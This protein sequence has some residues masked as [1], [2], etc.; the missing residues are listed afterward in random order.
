[1]LYWNDGENSLYKSDVMEVLGLLP[2]D[3]VDCVWTDP[4]YFLSDGGTTN[5]SG[6]R[7]KVDKGEW[8]APRSHQEHFSW[9]LQWIQECYRV[10]R[11]GGCIWLSGTVHAHPLLGMALLDC[12]YEIINDIVWEKPAPPP[13]LGRRSFTHS[14][15]LLYW[16]VK[17]GKRARYTF[18]YDDVRAGNEGKQVKTVWKI[19]P[20]NNEEKKHGKHPTQKPLELIDR[21]LEATTN[22]GDLVLDPFCGSG[23]SGVSALRLGRIWIGND[24]DIEQEYL[25]IAV[26]RL[27]EV[28]NALAQ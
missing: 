16:A 21:C 6:K 14:T 11:P 3:M 27:E 13:N 8:D 28:R 17:P 1:M 22:R 7:V 15:E 9:Y 26:K 4:P 2:S 12:G 10:L 5:R 23:S 18:N 19:S 20:P 25:P 24:F